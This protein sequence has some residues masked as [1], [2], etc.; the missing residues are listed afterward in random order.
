[1]DIVTN[2]RRLNVTYQGIEAMMDRNIGVNNVHGY[3]RLVT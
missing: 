1:M 2:M 3:E